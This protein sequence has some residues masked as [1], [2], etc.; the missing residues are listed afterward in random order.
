MSAPRIVYAGTPEFAV[1]ALSALIHR[2]QRVVAV[3][4]QPDRPAGR[5]RRPAISPVKQCALEAG[6]PVQ[7]PASLRDDEARA[8]LAGLRPDLLVVAAYGL[9]LPQAVLDIPALGCVN[10][11]ASLLPRWRGAAPVQ[12]ALLA[13][14]TRTGISIMCM[15]A[16]L[17]TGPVY[18]ADALDID[19]A[20]T[21]GTL[22]DR[23]ARLG[24]ESLMAALP[25][26]LD[27]RS[28]PRPQND[29]EATYAQKLRKEE[30]RIDWSQ[31]AEAIA[32]MVR[33]F[34]PWPVAQ[35]RLGDDVLRLWRASPLPD[36]APADPVAAP[37]TEPLIEPGRVLACARGGIDVATGAGILRITEL[38]APGKRRMPAADFLN[39]RKLEG[40][41][42]G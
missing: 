27:Q 11:H 39:A 8:E 12:R 20:D 17:D 7:Q 31:P 21:G 35:C 10:I 4:T 2:G 15:E 32:R 25:G 29:A 36:A 34:D 16:G 9:I 5:G 18:A 26:I 41:L 19:P 28:T 23:L 24:A 14:D 33:A 1:P 30:A 22:T 13:G 37:P 6:L 40:A 42:L 38:Q 3:Y